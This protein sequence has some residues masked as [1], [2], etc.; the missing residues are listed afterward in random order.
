LDTASVGCRFLA[1]HR[2]RSARCTATLKIKEFRSH[3]SHLNAFAF[4]PTVFFSMR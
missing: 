2:K 1:R 4:L 3:S